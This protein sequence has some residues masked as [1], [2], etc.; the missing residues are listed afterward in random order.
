MLFS[1][2]LK[3]ALGSRRILSNCSQTLTRHFKCI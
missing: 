2:H 1:Q 3:L